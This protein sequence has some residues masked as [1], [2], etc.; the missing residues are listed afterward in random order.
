MEG[1]KPNN[2]VS[3]TETS[4]INIHREISLKRFLF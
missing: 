4:T 3:C 2:L 1:K